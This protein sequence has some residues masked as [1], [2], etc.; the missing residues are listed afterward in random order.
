MASMTDEEMADEAPRRKGA[1]LAE[2]SAVIVIVVTWIVALARLTGIENEPLA[3]IIAFTPWFVVVAVLALALAIYARAW[4]AAGGALL[5]LVLHAWWLAPLF[6]G[7]ASGQAEFTVVTLNAEYGE[8][9]ATEIVQMVE[10]TGA[11]ILCI[12]ELTPSLV[13]ELVKAGLGAHL[14][15]SATKPETNH[16]GVGLWSRTQI[17]RWTALDELSSWAIR[18]EM[19][20]DAGEVTVYAVHPLPPM[21]T[22]QARW[23]E[24]LQALVDVV[25]EAAGPVIVA[26]DFNTTRDHAVFR[27][28]EALGFVDESDE[29]GAGLQFTFPQG[30]P[31]PPLV[32]IDHVLTRESP[33]VAVGVRTVVISGTDHRALVVDYAAR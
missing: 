24:D 4:A 2:S 27:E 25:S 5:L 8:A 3:V 16:A 31:L 1:R 7:E 33:W 22:S 6:V 23:D 15:F 9:N 14:P 20:T 11:D 32:A 29:A 10:D 18:A 12:Q 30:G 13:E 19:G 26:G 21:P 28:L 17:T